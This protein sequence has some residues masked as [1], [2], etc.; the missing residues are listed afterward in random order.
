MSRLLPCFPCFALMGCIWPAEE[1]KEKVEEKVEDVA[2]VSEEE[3]GEEED[4]LDE[5]WDEAVLLSVAFGTHDLRRHQAGTGSFT[6]RSLPDMWSQSPTRRVVR[7]LVSDILWNMLYRTGK[8]SGAIFQ[9]DEDN[10][11]AVA[12]TVAVSTVCLIATISSFCLYPKIS[13][14]CLE[15]FFVFQVLVLNGMFMF[16]PLTIADAT[17]RTLSL[18]WHSV[19]FKLL[20]L[21]GRRFSRCLLLLTCSCLIDAATQLA[22]VVLLGGH[23]YTG[24]LV[25]ILLVSA[26]IGL[27]CFVSCDRFSRC[28]KVQASQQ[29]LVEKILTEAFDSWAFLDQRKSISRCLADAQ[30]TRRSRGEDPVCQ[31][32]AACLGSSDIGTRDVRQAFRSVDAASGFRVEQA[33]ATVCEGGGDVPAEF[34]IFRLVG[35]QSSSWSCCPTR[36]S[37]RSSSDIPRYVV[38][39]RSALM[40]SRSVPQVVEHP[41]ADDARAPQA[42]ARQNGRSPNQLSPLPGVNDNDSLIQSDDVQSGGSDDASVISKA[43]RSQIRM[44][45]LENKSSSIFDVPPLEQ[46]CDG[47]GKSFRELV[48]LGRREHWIVDPQQLCLFESHTLGSGT[49]GTVLQ[50]TFYGAQVAIKMPKSDKKEHLPLLNE[51]RT[52]RRLRHPNIVLFLGAHV[53][54]STNDMALVFELIE[55]QTL[56]DWIKAQP[57]PIE[58]DAGKLNI[59]QGISLALRYL[60]QQDR[61][62]VHGDLK[63]SNVFVENGNLL[64]PKAKLGDFG[65]ARFLYKTE[66]TMGGSLRWMAPE[67]ATGLNRSPS[68]AADIFSLGA[69]FSFTLTDVKPFDGMDRSNILKTMRKCILPKLT[70]PQES[71]ELS[72]LLKS[73]GDSCYCLNP[74]DRPDIMQVL[75]VLDA[76]VMMQNRPAELM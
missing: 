73:I 62:L 14:D 3:E 22:G 57:H 6:T 50:G 65:L 23:P 29:E 10:L 55:G 54:P 67:I 46:E 51:L 49:F 53:V 43:A 44:A 30:G 8:L 41:P 70:W 75:E 34:V 13:F 16:L 32:L 52:L 59:L 45:G 63:G 48:D 20:A 64:L 7:S 12:A 68:C 66:H 72:R 58:C 56:H 1:Q 2:P 40:R 4:E 18:T 11:D 74:A 38:G 37:N 19:W 5:D 28:S 60:H 25:F 21:T 71:S 69:L 17:H 9:L 33:R 26:Y 15:R 27:M 36:S 76:C 47:Q 61:T 42:R 31:L 35:G 24:S 39:V